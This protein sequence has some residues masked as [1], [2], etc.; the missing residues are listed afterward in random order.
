VLRPQPESSSA[1]RLT[2]DQKAF[3]VML[4]ALHRGFR[5]QGA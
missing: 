5:V 1:S 3:A 2:W 4:R